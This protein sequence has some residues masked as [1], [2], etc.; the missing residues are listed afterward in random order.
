MPHLRTAAHRKSERSVGLFALAACVAL[1]VLAAH[2]LGQPPL[3]PEARRGPWP[4][5]HRVGVRVADTDAPSL[6]PSPPG[7]LSARRARAIGL[8]SGP[9]T[10]IPIESWPA[11]PRSPSVIDPEA[12]MRALRA[13]CPPSAPDPMVQRIALAALS[14]ARTFDID[15]FVLSALTYH[16][17]ACDPNVQDSYGIGLT[18][19]N[20]GMHAA[21]VLS[22]GYHYRAPVPEGGFVATALPLDGRPFTAKALLVPENNLYFA[23]AFLHVFE[24]Q[25]PEIDAPFGSVP[26]RHALSHFI[27]GDGVRSALPEAMVLTIRRRLL[28]YYAPPRRSECRYCSRGLASPLDGAPR[29]VIGVMGDPRDQGMRLHAGIDLMANEGEPVRAVAEGV[30]ISA[31]VDLG[32]EGLRDL[33]PERAVRVPLGRMGARGLFVRIAHKGGLVSLY[34]HLSSYRVQ[35]GE[36]VERGQP[37]GEVGLTGVHASNAHLHFG[38]FQ[39]DRAID[40]LVW[41]DPHVIAVDRGL[42]LGPLLEQLQSASG[43]P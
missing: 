38:L 29:I 36:S 2:V 18:R 12:F 5:R 21:H 8:R 28:G 11:E 32:A 34:A 23:A 30:V 41:L 9:R 37:I 4:V 27:F 15:P 22:D 19:I 35:V 43:A 16:Q 33:A 25:C 1:L 10:E 3:G 7:M 26:H 13:L 42:A 17:S 24:A 40:P 14:A 31:G 20:L 39:D 6:L